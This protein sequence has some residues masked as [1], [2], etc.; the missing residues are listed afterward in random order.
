MIGSPQELKQVLNQQNYLVDKNISTIVFLAA[1]LEKPLLVEGPAGVGKTQLGYALAAALGK[2][3]IRLQCYEGI[4][5]SKALY[6]WN[7]PRQL[8]RIQA[9]KV[10]KKLLRTFLDRNI[11]YSALY[12]V[13]CVIFTL[14]YY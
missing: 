13:P 11:Y 3:V 9:G 14:V 7:Y 2:Q 10:G 4:D 8:L 6:D 1:A 5:A 12:Y